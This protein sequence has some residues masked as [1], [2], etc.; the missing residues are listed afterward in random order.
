LSDFLKY[1]PQY[2]SS[3][4]SVVA[5]PCTADYLVTSELFNQSIKI[6]LYSTMHRKRIRGTYWRT[7]C[8][9][10]SLATHGAVQIYLDWL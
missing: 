10:D 1:K 4:S 5:V 9:S 8:T 7:L 2:S 3:G 6:N